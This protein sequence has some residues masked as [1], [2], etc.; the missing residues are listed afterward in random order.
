[1][2]KGTSRTPTSVTLIG[3]I[4]IVVAGCMILSGGGSLVFSPVMGEDEENG[5]LVE[6]DNLPQSSEV[7][8]TT[9]QYF[10]LLPVIQILLGIFVLIV[11][12][13]FLKLRLWARST[14][15]VVTWSSLV[16]KVGYGTFCLILWIRRGISSL[17]EVPY[18]I[19][20]LMRVAPWIWALIFLMIIK[21]L[22]GRTARKAFAQA[23][24]VF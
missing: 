6:S 9:F 14:L 12:I 10:D 5:F 2:E 4:F 11:A 13:Q 8:S 18:V 21:F 15:E 22:R 23:Q 24:C 20:T 16:Y 3:L 7:L 19:E 17:N 1:M